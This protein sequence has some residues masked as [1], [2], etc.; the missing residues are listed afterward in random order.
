[1]LRLSAQICKQ[2]C[3][4]QRLPGS[5]NK[6]PTIRLQL[7]TRKMTQQP[8]KIEWTTSIPIGNKDKDKITA[9]GW[10]LLV[11]SLKFKK[12]LLLSALCSSYPRPHL[13]WACGR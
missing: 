2:S 3:A 13:A 10:F 11:S 9:L 7:V 6:I 4:M 5:T 1:M 8:Q 12:F